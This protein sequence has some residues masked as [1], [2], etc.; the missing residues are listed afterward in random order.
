VLIVSVVCQSLS[1]LRPLFLRLL[2]NTR[3][4]CARNPQYRKYIT[5]CNVARA[6]C[7][8]THGPQPCAQI[9]CGPLTE[10][11]EPTADQADFVKLGS[12]QLNPMSLHSTLVWKLPIIEHKIERNGCRWWK[13][14]RPRDKPHDVDSD[15]NDND[16][17][18]TIL[19]IVF[20]RSDLIRWK[21][22]LYHKRLLTA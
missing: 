18:A 8:S 12:A 3:V 20:A 15:D 10:A 5:H 22:E 11:L 17:D 6:T 19:S 13:W 9:Q 7:R 21:L 16:N 1:I 4:A 14:K 2:L